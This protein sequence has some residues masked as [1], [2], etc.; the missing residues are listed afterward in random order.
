MAA[1][2]RAIGSAGLPSSMA[3]I[4]TARLR[5][6]EDFQ[7]G[8]PLFF[9]DLPSLRRAP[10]EPAGA[11]SLARVARYAFDPFC[12]P[13]ALVVDH[14]SADPAP[15]AH[16][17]A[18]QRARARASVGLT[19]DALLELRV[20]SSSTGF[21]RHFGGGSYSFCLDRHENLRSRPLH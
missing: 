17:H 3:A 4:M 5:R 10:L 19:Q 8:P 1:H 6:S 9:G 7:V 12:L 13:A 14:A 20:E 11:D 18:R 16:G 15:S 21:L 2:A